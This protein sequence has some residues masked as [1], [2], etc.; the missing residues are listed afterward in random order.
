MHW[1][2]ICILKSLECQWMNVSNSFQSYRCGRVGSVSGSQEAL[3]SGEGE[4]DTGV[5]WEGVLVISYLSY[6][7][8]E[9]Q[10]WNKWL[11][12]MSCHVFM[13]F[14]G[15]VTVYC[16]IATTEGKCVMIN[17]SD[18][19]YKLFCHCRNSLSFYW[20]FYIMHSK[21]STHLQNTKYGKYDYVRYK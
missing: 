4:G 9:K 1:E 19:T 6:L 10:W 14:L 18:M 5:R 15:N 16:F 20:F 13:L 2:I 21:Y 11:I 17:E 12:I 7:F 8:H 3:R